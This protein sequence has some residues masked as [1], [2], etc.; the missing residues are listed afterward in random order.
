MFSQDGTMVQATFDQLDTIADMCEKH[1]LWMHVDAAWGGS[2]SNMY[3]RNLYFSIR[4]RQHFASWNPH[5]MLVAGPPCSALLLR[6]TT[7]W[8]SIATYLFQYAAVAKQ[9]TSSFIQHGQPVFVNLCFWFIPPSLRGKEGNTVD[10]AI[11]ERMRQRGTMM[12]WTSFLMK[13]K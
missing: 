3:A 5:K 10:P 9:S 4:R 11:K 8:I 2:V 7:V 1:K 12:I 6:D 13:W